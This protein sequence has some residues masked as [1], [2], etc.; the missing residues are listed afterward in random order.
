M[1]TELQAATLQEGTQQAIR[2]ELCRRYIGTLLGMYAVYT[3]HAA[4]ADP[5]LDNFSKIGKVIK[6]AALA[7]LPLAFKKVKSD[8]GNSLFVMKVDSITGEA[9]ERSDVLV[10]RTD[11]DNNNPRSSNIDCFL[12]DD[13]IF[14]VNRVNAQE[15]CGLSY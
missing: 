8:V 7:E 14:A 15:Y 13:V 5:A 6:Q 11:C 3:D 9:V 12:I 10:G 2:N 4:D 1:L